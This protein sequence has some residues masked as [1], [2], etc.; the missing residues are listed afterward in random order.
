LGVLVAVGVDVGYFWGVAVGIAAGGI[1]TEVSCGTG[2][3]TSGPQ[4]TIS[5]AIGLWGFTG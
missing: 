4:G 5:L 1:G 2:F 3:T